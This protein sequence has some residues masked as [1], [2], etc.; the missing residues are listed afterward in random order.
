MVAA[1][2]VVTWTGLRT[3][4]GIA[5]VQLGSDSAMI[6]FMLVFHLGVRQSLSCRSALVCAWCKNPAK[7]AVFAG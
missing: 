3:S 7:C 1:A 6:G 2:P 5:L 4:S